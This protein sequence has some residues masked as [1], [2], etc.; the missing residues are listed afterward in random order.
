MVKRIQ[1]IS[2]SLL[3]LLVVAI[4]LL[5]AIRHACHELKKVEKEA[6]I[7]YLGYH[8]GELASLRTLKTTGQNENP[9]I[10][11]HSENSHMTIRGVLVAVWKDGRIIW[12][13]NR[14]REERGG[15]PYFEG[16][17]SE[18]K[19]AEVLEK[20]KKTGVFDDPFLNIEELSMGRGYELVIS[21]IDGEKTLCMKSKQN[22]QGSSSNIKLSFRDLFSNS[23]KENYFYY[24]MHNYFKIRTYIQET[25]YSLIPADGKEIKFDYSIGHINRSDGSVYNWSIPGAEDDDPIICD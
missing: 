23:S 16:K 13:K 25:V 1:Y 10:L 19:I 8:R 7:Y 2:L 24:R 14:G 3:L 11:I 15:R 9:V 4:G 21:I 12:S 17:I 6:E 5:F 22:F 20:L 18:K